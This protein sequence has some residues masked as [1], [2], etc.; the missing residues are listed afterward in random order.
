[1]NDCGVIYILKRQSQYV[2][3]I[4]HIAGKALE[5]VSLWKLRLRRLRQIGVSGVIRKTFGK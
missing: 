2:P 4:V 5:P 1:M 3:I